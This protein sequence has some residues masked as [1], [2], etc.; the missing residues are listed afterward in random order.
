MARLPV[1]ASCFGLALLLAT[2]TASADDGWNPFKER[3]QARNAARAARASAED[4]GGRTD[5]RSPLP[6]MSGIADKPWLDAARPTGGPFDRAETS[7]TVQQ[8]APWSEAPPTSAGPTAAAS[9]SDTVQRSELQP[10]TAPLGADVPQG[11]WQSIDRSRLQALIAPLALPPRSAAMGRL[12]HRLWSDAPGAPPANGAT[13]SG[14][15]SGASFE[16]IRLEVLYRSGHLAG[17]AK[18]V[19][20]MPAGQAE[21]LTDLLIARTRLMVGEPGPA[22]SSIKDLQR[23]QAAFPKPARQE[24]MVL[25]ALCGMQNGDSGTAG[26]A[27]DLLRAENITAPVPLAVLDAMASGTSDALALPPAK[28]IGLIDYRFIE[29]TRA[30]SLAGIVATAEPALLAHLASASTDAETRILAAEAAVAANIVGLPELEAA[31]RAASF[32]PDALASPLAESQT[33]ALKRALLFKALEAERTPIKKARLARALLDEARRA[34]GPYMQVAAMLGPVI[35]DIR[36][37]QE[38]GWFAETA[39][40][41]GLASGRTEALMAWTNPPFGERYGGLKHWLVLADIADPASRG[42]R[43]EHL[44]AVERFA[45][46]GR[47]S[48]ELM[49]RLVTVLDALDYQIPI[50]LWEA[51][52]R[53]P[54]PTTGHLP[55]TGVLSELQDAAKRQE[56]G[57]VVLTAIRTLGPDSSATAHMIALGD[58]IRALKRAG[59]EPDARRLG[60]EALFVGW[61]RSQND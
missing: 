61:P 15:S 18:A 17:L 1:A 20:A 33:P 60:L 42:R 31:Y 38:I 24:F 50:P 46:R 44:P 40:E 58:T 43:G 4:S 29:L 23:H 59:L 28:S 56:Q 2:S 57:L 51:A 47:L 16:A 27:A 52:S 36:P 49:H 53:S 10:L 55:E 19:A 12:W 6:P 26:L 39:I 7:L 30:G 5:E 48:P 8:P 3:D 25:A 35:N 45:V 11:L 22:C 37:A 21:P 13:G 41:I 32:S 14:P 54:Q 9:G 34:Q